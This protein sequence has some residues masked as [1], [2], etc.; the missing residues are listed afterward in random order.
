[1][2]M[3]WKSRGLT[4]IVVITLALGTGVNT[5]IFSVLNG[6]LLRPLPV[7]G[8]DE[9]IVLAAQVPGSS[10]FSYPAFE[11]FRQQSSANHG[12]FRL[13]PWRRRAEHQRPGK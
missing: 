6:W 8:P 12:S 2:R 9:I 7:R 5:A 11:D 10:T 4:A 1:M 3:L 13:H